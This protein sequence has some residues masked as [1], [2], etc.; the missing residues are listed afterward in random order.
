MKM[1]VL[2]SIPT[3]PFNSMLRNGTA[4]EMI[5]R[6]V[7]DNKPESIYFTELDGNRGAVMIV[8]IP[9]ASKIP[10]ISEPWYLNFEALCEFKIVMSPD[11]LMKADLNSLGKKWS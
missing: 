3:E 6:V 5:E 2:V 9:N 4:G 8:E 7:D 11:D 10:S 1:L